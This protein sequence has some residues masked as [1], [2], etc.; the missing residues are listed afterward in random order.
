M[1][2]SV[3]YNQR[4]S[5]IVGIENDYVAFCFD[6]AC[7]Y[8]MNALA[9]NQKIVFDDDSGDESK[10]KTIKHYNSLDEMY[11]SMRLL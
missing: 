10:P 3:K 4:P 6:E 5:S 8:L 1:A 7:I 2:I 9:N 11:A